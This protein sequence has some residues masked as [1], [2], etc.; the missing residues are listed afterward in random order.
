MIAEL[1]SEKKVVEVTGQQFHQMVVKFF[2][3]NPFPTC[4]ELKKALVPSGVSNSAEGEE[5]RFGPNG[6]FKYRFVSSDGID[7]MVK[8]HGIDTEVAKR[9]P[10]CNAAK[11]WTAQIVCDYCSYFTWEAERKK[12]GIVT[13]SFR[14]AQS[15]VAPRN[16]LAH[17]PLR[18]GPSSGAKDWTHLS[19][20]PLAD[21]E[22]LVSFVFMGI[23]KLKCIIKIA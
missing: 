23:F 8:Y 1:N 18:S 20:V 9:Y 22:N 4:D 10:D 3:K 16:D 11:G 2:K 15:G 5:G 6:I 13:V 14:K 12:A 21:E 17:I 19:K 7:L